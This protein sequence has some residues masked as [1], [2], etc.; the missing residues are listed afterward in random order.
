MTIAVD[1]DLNIKPLCTLNITGWQ[2][3]YTSGQSVNTI[4]HLFMYIAFDDSEDH[5]YDGRIDKQCR[6]EE[7]CICIISISSS[8]NLCLLN[9]NDLIGDLEI[10][11]E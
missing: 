1:W 7:A 2:S 6:P 11:T 10:L 5:F 8:L 3:I 4:W 9:K